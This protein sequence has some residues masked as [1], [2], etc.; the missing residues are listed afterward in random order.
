[1]SHSGVH[2]THCCAIHGCKYC[3]DDCPVVLGQV[4]QEIDCEDC[5]YEKLRLDAAMRKAVELGVLQDTPEHR[6]ALR[7]IIQAAEAADMESY[8]GSN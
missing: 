3:D 8:W 7:T 4:K 6:E 1:M 5:Q 2:A